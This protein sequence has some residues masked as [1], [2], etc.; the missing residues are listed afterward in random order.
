[1]QIEQIE[2]LEFLKRHSPFQEL[3]EETQVQVASQI[4]I[5]YFKAGTPI[6]SFGQSLDALYLI[7]SGA[8]ETYR[9]N[10]DLY[11]RLSEGGIFAEQGLLRSKTVRFP[12]SALEDT[13]LYLIPATLFDEL[14]ENHDLFADYVMVS[15]EERRKAVPQRQTDANELMTSKVNTLI[16]REPVTLTTD[17]SVR[18]AAITMQHE[19]VS[20][21]LV[22]QPETQAEANRDGKINLIAGIITDRDIRNRLVAPGLPFDT[23]IGDIMTRELVT[24]QHH[25]FV[26]EAMLIML[27]HNV[28]HLPVMK[29][30][31]PIGVIAISDIVR[32]ESKNSLFVV[33]SIFRQQSVTELQALSQDVKACFVRMVNEDANSHMIGSAMA[34]IGRSFKQR[35][36]ELAEEQLGPPPVPY[37]FLALGSMAREEQLIVTDQDNALILHNDFDARQHDVYFKQL[38]DFVCDGLAACGYTYCTGGIMATNPKWRQPLQVW[39]KY[40]RDWIDNPSPE[41]LLHSSIFFDIA[42]VWGKVEWAE[43]LNKDMVRHASRSKRFLASMARNALLRTPPLGFFKDFVMENDGRQNNSL[44]I[45]RRGTAP[46]ADLIRVHAL[47][48]GCEQQNSFQ[49]L[50]HIIN[51]K[52]IPPGRAEDIRDALEVIAM[53]RIRH[54]AIALQAGEEPD[55]NVAPEHLSDF[56]RRNLKEAFQVLSNAQKYLKFRYQGG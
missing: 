10:G 22:L 16:G 9:R 36:L 2:I 4:E 42:G 38:A 12:A 49:R 31:R 20:S 46:L 52:L 34:V 6:L 50:K 27:R 32:Y 47:A 51:A 56:E 8:V 29:Q 24:I 53:A 15:D 55:N 44:N 35:L 40:F 54:Q 19:S 14:F 5:S 18:D 17:A 41:R 13:L 33:S 26:F 43:Q 1:M 21:L 7:R 30:G 48:S 39:Q 23:A 45:K 28:H 37:C 3:P 25:Q 11:N